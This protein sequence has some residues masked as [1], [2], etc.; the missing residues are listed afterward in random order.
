MLDIWTDKQAEGEKVPIPDVS[1]FACQ[2]L[3]KLNRGLYLQNHNIL[4][5]KRSLLESSR[6]DFE[7]EK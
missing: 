7:A 2:F 1:E 5:G 6:Q 4:E 3:E